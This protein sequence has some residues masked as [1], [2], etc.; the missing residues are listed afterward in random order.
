MLTLFLALQAAAPA[1][2]PPDDRCVALM[3]QPVGVATASAMQWE[4]TVGGAVARQCLGLNFANR[5]DWAG[6]AAAFEGAARLAQSDD[7]RI[8]TY[9]AQAGNAWLAAGQPAKA[10][11][12]LER[13]L[14]AKDLAG[15]DRGQAELDHGRALALTGD[16][17][18]ARGAIDRALPL[19]DEDPLVWLLSA[20]LARQTGD[21]ARAR[22]DIAQAVG[23]AAD[24]PAVQ[25]EAGNIAARSGDEA[26]AKAAW[27]QVVKLRPDSPQGK[28]AAAALAQFD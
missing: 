1:A 24:D 20:T 17:A 12:A 18:G 21:L 19:V 5:G 27:Q 2:A 6:A 22:T 3:K 25:L 16:R 13:A 7:P 28:A 4:R 10:V 9:W 23:R 15:F 14:A 11:P 8:A 26:G